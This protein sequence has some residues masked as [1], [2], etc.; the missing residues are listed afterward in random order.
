MIYPHSHFA[1]YPD[2]AHALPFLPLHPAAAPLCSEVAHVYRYFDFSWE[3]DGASMKV[4]KESYIMNNPRR[5]MRQG[6]IPHAM[7]RSCPSRPAAVK[8]CSEVAHAYRYFDVS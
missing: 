5:I 2:V 6:I 7:R 8:L 4:G 1:Q 3:D